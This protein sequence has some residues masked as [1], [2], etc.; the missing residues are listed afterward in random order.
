MSE[1]D[2]EAARHM[3]AVGL[4]PQE[5]L[6]AAERAARKSG[7]PLAEVLVELGGVDPV[8]L[9]NAR[10]ALV[11]RARWC[12]RCAAPVPVPRL[13][14]E[15]ER[16]PICLGPVEWRDDPGRR[17]V[18]DTVELTQLVQDE[19]PA[20]VLLARA[21]RSNAFGKYVLLKVIGRGGAGIVHKAWDTFLGDYVAIKFIREPGGPADSPDARAVRERQVYDLIKEAR[22]IARLKH[23][24]IIAIR[25]V[26]RVAMLEAL[27]QISLA[28]HHAHSLPLPVIH[29]DLKPA[30]ILMARDGTAHVMDFGIARIIGG[31]ERYAEIAGTPAYMAPEQATRDAAIGA[32]TDVYGLG[33]IL[34]ELLC[35]RP[36]FVGE[37]PEVLRGVLVE[38]PPLPSE[39]LRAR[40]GRDTRVLQP[41]SLLEAACMRCLMKDPAKRYGSARAVAAELDTVLQALRS[42][43]VEKDIVPEALRTAQRDADIRRVDRNLTE[44]RLQEA[45][46]AAARIDPRGM[47]DVTKARVADRRRHAA[48]VAALHERLVHRLNAL[49]PELPALEL[50]SGSIAGAEVIKATAQRLIVFH[51]ERTLEVPW[52]SLRPAQF[53]ALVE[54]V[55]LDEPQ[56][57]LALLIYCRH[58]RLAESAAVLARSLEGTPLA[59]AARALMAEE[60]AQ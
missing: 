13:A 34:Y 16:C 4:L 39:I 10:A 19:L 59:Q 30:N 18:E 58:A 50:V 7:R 29:C 33:G 43:S 11:E 17:A 2:A 15:G 44:L 32:W 45:V 31:T 21:D 46:D 3:V 23:S 24:N 38:T 37:T 36:M 54:A 12:A 35:G 42:R 52:T 20:E 56:D 5:D 55:G 53:V 14:K 47:G 60:D 51:K 6:D 48:E 49:R 25:D 22:A 27:L 8:Q 28:V 41:L 26:G 1:R 57:R 40:S 9:E